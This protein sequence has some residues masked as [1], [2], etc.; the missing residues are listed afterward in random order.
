MTKTLLIAVSI[1]MIGLATLYRSD[2]SVV[3]EMT[4]TSYDAKTSNSLNANRPVQDRRR[5]DLPES[6]LVTLTPRGF[7]PSEVELPHKPFLLIVQNRTGLPKVDLAFSGRF[8][9][10]PKGKRI[11]PVK[12]PWG[13]RV[14]L[15]PGI[16]K[17]S[18]AN[19]PEWLM[20]IS[21]TNDQ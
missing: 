13:G 19:H 9:S 8:V 15:P 20:T 5:H 1:I 21:I 14:D 11:P 3:A 12:K 6:L 16:Y 2:H 10:E 7:E 18:E 17:L 4:A